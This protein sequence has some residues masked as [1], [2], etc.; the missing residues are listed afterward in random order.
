MR[1]WALLLV[2]LSAAAPAAQ[3]LPDIPEDLL[4]HN[5]ITCI[6][7]DNSGKVV[8]AY[9]VQSTGDAHRDREL[10][11][12]VRKLH[13]PKVKA[14]EKSRNIWFPMPIAFGNATPPDSPNACNR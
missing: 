9:I 3:G 4:N 13:W 1:F 11:A 7:M 2:A 8:G 14:G 12:W 10:V 6:K 5:A